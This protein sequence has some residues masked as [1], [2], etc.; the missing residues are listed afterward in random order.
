MRREEGLKVT[1]LR[2]LDYWEEVVGSG[3]YVM[4]K[5]EKKMKSEFS[6]QKETPIFFIADRKKIWNPRRIFYRRK[7]WFYYQFE[8][9]IVKN[10]VLFR[11]LTRPALLPF[12]NP[13]HVPFS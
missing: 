13:I 11:R 9:R 3:A 7:K 5:I 8:S 2:Y 4:S 12:R 1:L 10:V 6:Y